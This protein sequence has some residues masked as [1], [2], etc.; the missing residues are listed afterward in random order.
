M[1]RHTITLVNDTESNKLFEYL[2]N[3][4]RLL[5]IYMFSRDQKI[6]LN[7]LVIL[8]YFINNTNKKFTL[9]LEW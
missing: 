9:D 7:S 3:Y 2:E 8:S 1:W 5:Y 4:D 6:E